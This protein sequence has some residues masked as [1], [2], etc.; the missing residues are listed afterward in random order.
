MSWHPTLSSIERRTDLPQDRPR[1]LTDDQRRV[2]AMQAL[3][4]LGTWDCWCG[5]ERDHDWPG[6]DD[7]KPHPRREVLA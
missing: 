7:G 3:G 2:A 4:S 1:P 5:M 6:K